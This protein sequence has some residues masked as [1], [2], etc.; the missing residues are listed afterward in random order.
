[1]VKIGL[2]TPIKPPSHFF[3]Q[4]TELPEQNR[5]QRWSC[6]FNQYPTTFLNQLLVLIKRSF[7]IISRDMTLTASRILTHFSIALILGILY[8]GIGKDASNLTNNFNFLFFTVMFLMLT[9]M[10]CVITTCKYTSLHL[11][12]RETR[13]PK[14][15]RDI[16]C[17][18][19][20]AVT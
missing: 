7:L 2:L 5:H 4:K 11:S 20:C 19:T 16:S 8:F 15:P 14:R 9:A 1:M 17:V 12:S 3:P 18:L 13:S 6:C 10:N